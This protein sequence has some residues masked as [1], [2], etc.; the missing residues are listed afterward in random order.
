MGN[1]KNT[2]LPTHTQTR[3]PRQLNQPIRTRCV[4]CLNWNGRL[5][6]GKCA[7]FIRKQ[8]EWLGWG[9]RV[10]IYDLVGTR[11]CVKNQTCWLR[12]RMCHLQF[13]LTPLYSINII[14]L[15]RQMWSLHLLRLIWLISNI[16]NFELLGISV[17]LHMY[18]SAAFIWKCI[19]C[20]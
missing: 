6:S 7:L 9:F 14:L 4:K 10:V 15:V 1:I 20:P 16:G 17:F 8:K 13:L 19:W 18:P 3:K 11:K 5:K 2:R 12:V